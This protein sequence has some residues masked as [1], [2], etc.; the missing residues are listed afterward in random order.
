MLKKRRC[1]QYISPLYCSCIFVYCIEVE[2]VE[3]EEVYAV[4]LTPV[5]QLFARNRAK[6]AKITVKGM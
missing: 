4:H 6:A 3:E 2:Y 5:L 1:M